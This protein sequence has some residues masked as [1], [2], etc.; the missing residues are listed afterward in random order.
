MFPETGGIKALD[1]LYHDPR[2]VVVHVT[3]WDHEKQQVYFTRP[4]YP[5][6][7]MQPVWKFQQYFTRVLV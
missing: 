6:E 4:G 2:G 3:G 1:R 7:C 5:H